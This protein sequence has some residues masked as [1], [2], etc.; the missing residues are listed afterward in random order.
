MK[1]FILVGSYIL[2][3]LYAFLLKGWRNEL[4]DSEWDV[5]LKRQ[6]WKLQ[7]ASLTTSNGVTCKL[8]SRQY[9]ILLEG[10]RIFQ[11][12]P[13]WLNA[14]LYL[15]DVPSGSL[16]AETNVHENS[17]LE[18][19]LKNIM[20]QEMDRAYKAQLEQLFRFEAARRMALFLQDRDLTY[21]KERERIEKME[22]VYPRY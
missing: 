21:S 19:F 10:S 13:V 9:W 12:G 1:A 15:A 17:A 16:I 4:R 5:A 22:K 7:D 8:Q 20:Q 3:G 14:K 11:D 18:Y 2:L 6:D